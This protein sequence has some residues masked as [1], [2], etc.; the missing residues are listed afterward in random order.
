GFSTRFDAALDMRMDQRQEKTAAD[1]LKRYSEAELHKLFEQWGEVTNSRTL[2]KTIVEKRGVMPL[3]SIADFKTALSGI[4]KGNPAKYFAQVFQALRIEVNDEMGALKEL[5]TQLPQVLKTGGRAAIITFHSIEDRLVKQFFKVNTFEEVEDHPFQTTE[6]LQL[7]KPV[8]KKPIEG[9][10][11]YADF[12]EVKENGE[13]KL[14]AAAD[15]AGNRLEADAGNTGTGSISEVLTNSTA[16]AIDVTYVY[17]VTANGCINASNYNVVVRVNPGPMLTSTLAP[18]GIC[19]GSIL[20]YI[21]TSNAAGVTF[22]WSRASIATINGNGSSAG[23]GSVSEVLTNASASPVDVTYVYSLTANG[24]TSPA[25]NVV[26][27]VS[28]MPTLTSPLTLPTICSG[29]A[30]VYN[31]TSSTSGVTFSW[32]RSANA[33]ING[34]MPAIGNGNVNEVLNNSSIYPVDVTYLYTLST[35]GCNSMVYS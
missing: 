10:I 1:V 25:Y 6:K 17:A 27:R 12:W 15:S 8:N 13:F 18:S 20:D 2:A 21:P 14:I 31:T 24:C 30:F 22:S 34:N 32:T 5:L 7:L 11:V 3:L 23:F 26:V 29:S 16:T 35:G 9:F 28:P 4:V 19:S 33:S